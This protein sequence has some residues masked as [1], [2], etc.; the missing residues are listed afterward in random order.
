MQEPLAS[1]RETTLLPCWR[2]ETGNKSAAIDRSF[3]ELESPGKP[4]K[5]KHEIRPT[6]QTNKFNQN[7]P[8]VPAAHTN[9]LTPLLA[10]LDKRSPRE[11][12]S[13]RQ[14]ASLPHKVGCRRTLS[15]LTLALCLWSGHPG[16]LPGRAWDVCRLKWG[17]SLSPPPLLVLPSSHS[18]GATVKWAVRPPGHW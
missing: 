11:A 3:R 8:P 12:C 4:K 9:L 14:C 13:F 1:Q 2:W 16:H 17:Y 18:L 5:G 15:L 7:K 10:R 6:A